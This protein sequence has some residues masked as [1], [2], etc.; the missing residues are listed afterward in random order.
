MA[1]TLATSG[2]TGGGYAPAMGSI[3]ACKT[4]NKKV[5]NYY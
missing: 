4:Y 2:D 1:Y 3:R 5:L